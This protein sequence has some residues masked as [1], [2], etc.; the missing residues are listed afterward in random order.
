MK[1]SSSSSEF[2]H[3]PATNA[4]KQEKKAAAAVLQMIVETGERWMGGWMDGEKRE[5]AGGTC[6][7]ETRR[8]LNSFLL[9]VETNLRCSIS[10]KLRKT[11]FSES[12][13]SRQKREKE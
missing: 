11:Y 13:F 12:T 10:T 2:A 8:L 3:F 5:E 9:C 4:V 6:S 7:A 1:A